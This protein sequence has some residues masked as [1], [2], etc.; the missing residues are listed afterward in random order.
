MRSLSC[1]C[2]CFPYFEKNKIKV[3]LCDHLAL[4]SVCIPPQI[5]S[6]QRLGKHFPAATNTR[7][8]RRVVRRVVFNAVRVVSK[9]RR[10]LVL[11][12][13]SCFFVLNENYV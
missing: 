12:R 1:L 3:G 9:E 5:V 2:A 13:T 8:N 6:Q 11:P 7:N 4:V 10:R